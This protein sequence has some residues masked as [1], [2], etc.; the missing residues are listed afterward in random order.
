MIVPDTRSWTWVLDRACQE[1]GFDASQVDASVVARMVRENAATWLGLGQQAVIRPGRPDEGTWSTL[2]Y[3]CHVRDIY[4]LYDERVD[5]ML[6]AE[7]PDFPDWD[8]DGSAVEDRYEDQLP[9]RVVD[10]LA[11]A[12][13]ELAFRLD[14]IDPHAWHRS[15]RR[16]DGASFTIE[17]LSRYMIHDTTHHLWDVSKQS[18]RDADS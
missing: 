14:R 6:T 5:L 10:E 8:Q 13:N 17:S 18:N 12:G 7:H 3:A 2:E 9:T 1:C 11:A 16:S 15:G 4:R